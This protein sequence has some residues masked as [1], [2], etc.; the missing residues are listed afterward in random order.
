VKAGKCVDLGVD[1]NRGVRYSLRRSGDVNGLV[2]RR[3]RFFEPLY[4]VQSGS[5]GA[6]IPNG[7][8]WVVFCL[9][10]APRS[11]YLLLC[12]IDVAQKKRRNSLLSLG[13]RC[14]LVVMQLDR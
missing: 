1:R 9:G 8:G 4:L 3:Q 7:R 13:S 11:D 6:R 2:Q 5:K 14:Q 10:Q 12:G